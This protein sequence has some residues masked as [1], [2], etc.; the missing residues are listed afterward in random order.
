VVASLAPLE[1]RLLAAVRQYAFVE[2]LAATRVVIAPGDKS[3]T[4]RGAAALVAYEGA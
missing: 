4:M 1:P 2:G 3:V